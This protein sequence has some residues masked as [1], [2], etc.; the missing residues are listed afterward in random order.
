M[1]IRRFI[2]KTLSTFFYIGYLPLAPGT[3]ATVAGV[4]IF[5]LAKDSL[6]TYSLFILL[7]LVLGFLVS[8]PAERIFNKKDAR[9][10]VIDEV[11]GMLL[12]FVF[13]PYDVR[14]LVLGFFLFRFFDIL[15]PFPANRIQDLHGSLGIMGDDIV[16]GLYTNIILQLILRFTSLIA[17]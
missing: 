14:L 3:F 12:C 4:F 17:S 10:I 7:S 16:A 2:V 9:C 13:M 6:V 8:G 15:K 11:A 5:Y 1:A